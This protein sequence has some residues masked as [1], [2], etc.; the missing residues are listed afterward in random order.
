LVE[1]IAVLVGAA[2]CMWVAVVFGSLQ[3]NDLWP[4]PGLFFIEIVSL[5]LIALFSRL[6]DTRT[7]SRDYGAITWIVSGALLAFVLLGILSIGPFLI[8]SMFAFA[9]AGACGDLRKGR[10][11]PVHIRLAFVAAVAQAGLIAMFLI[12]SSGR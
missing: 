4:T 5:G 9:L 12:L 2:G 3:F 10:N 11:M 8:P 1:L 7:T 6:G